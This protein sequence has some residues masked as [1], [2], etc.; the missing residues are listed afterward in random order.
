MAARILR[1]ELRRSVAL[2]AGLVIAAVGVF[3]LFAS[4]E[5]YPSW[6]QLVVTQRD[7]M[8]LTWPL[9]LGAG[10]WQGI[11][12][13]RSR[14]EELLT[15]VARPRWQRVMPVAGAMAVG[16][17]AAYVVMLSGAAGHLRH[18][19]GYFPVGAIA[20]IALGALAMV[21]A[22]WFGL[23]L[24]A[25]L[26]SPLTAPMLVVAGFV[27]MAVVP[28]VLRVQD[29]RDPGTILLLP[30]LRGPSNGLSGLEMLSARANLSQ[31]LWLVALA[32]TAVALFAA[33][34]RRSRILALVPV[35]L[36]GAIAVPIMPGQ[37][38]SA[39]VEDRRATEV[40]CTPDEPRVCTARA[41]SYIFGTLRKPARQALSILAAKL[42]PAP[43][44]VLVE[45]PGK[46]P[47]RR[48]P[49]D[50]LLVYLPVFD[51]VTTYSAD[52]LLWTMLGGAGVPPCENLGGKAGAIDG[53]YMAARLVAAAWLLDRDVPAAAERG[54]E[55]TETAG[56]GPEAETA[57]ANDA[58]A[59]LRALPAEEQRARV[60]ALRD[61]ERTCAVGDRLELLTGNPR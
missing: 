28:P 17:V 24:G 22:V 58:L 9:A 13:R 32:A 20:L 40:V 42:P 35:V 18:V 48:P 31:A 3:V 2:W 7:I 37:F 47:D 54:S 21:A 11:R 51:D 52:T 38:D 15:T 49:E 36:G 27:G 8:Q 39:W 23:A 59:A 60:T 25:L 61:A 14:V 16:A 43:V 12:E 5:P 41:H 4:N 6:M 45:D 26:P 53:T 46:D 33:A 30:H 56:P 34:G 44:R 10:A 50:T 57:L 19:N 29:R 1:I 55:S